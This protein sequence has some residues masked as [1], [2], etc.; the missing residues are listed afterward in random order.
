MG[1]VALTQHDNERHKGGVANGAFFDP[2]LG[3][4]PEAYLGLLAPEA[5]RLERLNDSLNKIGKLVQGRH[6]LG[7]SEGNPRGK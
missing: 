4:S 3:P 7:S 2:E 1:I 5:V 6:G